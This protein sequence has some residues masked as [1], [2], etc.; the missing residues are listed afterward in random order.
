MADEDIQKKTA[1]ITPFGL[2]EFVV[3]SCATQTFQ[4][5]I[6]SIFRDLAYVFCYIDD[7]IVTSKSHEQHVEHLQTMFEHQPE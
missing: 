2:F 3:M 7:I 4:R 6:D 1:I 5:Y